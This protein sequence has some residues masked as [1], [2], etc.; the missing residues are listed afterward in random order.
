V[1][2]APDDQ[3]DEK[4]GPGV[5]YFSNL[6]LEAA[7]DV[8]DIVNARLKAL[9]PPNADNKELKPRLQRNGNPGYLGVWLF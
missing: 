1:V 3:R 5:D 2:R 7:Q 9:Q 4:G 6:A 8:A